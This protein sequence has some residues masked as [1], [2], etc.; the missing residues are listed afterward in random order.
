MNRPHPTRPAVVQRCV[1]VAL[2]LALAFGAAPPRPTRAQPLA[3]PDAN[4]WGFT[5][6][7]AEGQ[8]GFSDILNARVGDNGG[9][10]VY[11]TRHGAEG[12]YVISS[13]TVITVATVGTV[14]SGTLGTIAEFDPYNVEVDR[15]NRVVFTARVTGSSLP[16][17]AFSI[18]WPAFRW[19]NGVIT[20]LLPSASNVQHHL[21]TMT[22]QHQWLA[23][24]TTG[25]TANGSS[26][27][28][29]TDGVTVTPITTFTRTASGC[30]FVGYYSLLDLNASGTLL[31]APRHHTFPMLA[32]DA[33]DIS[34]F[35]RQWSLG[36]AGTASSTIAS[37]QLNFDF[38][39]GANGTQI[40]AAQIN[41]LGAVAY[42]KN[43]HT[44][45]FD[46]N[47]ITSQQLIRHEAG[48]ETVLLTT[49]PY[50][51]L[52]GFD[53]AGRVALARLDD[54]NSI[55]LYAGPNLT[56]DRVVGLGD[57][58]FGAELWGLSVL[59]V[60][61]PPATFGDQRVF[62]FHY[63]LESGVA[64]V[65]LASKGVT[66][67][68]NPAGGAWSTAANWLPDEVP[69]AAT[70]TL[71]D[72]E[73]AYD[74]NVGARTSGRSS[75]QNGSVGFRSAA[76]DL[77]GPLAVGADGAL[78][79]PEGNVTASD[80]I[81]GSLPP[82]NP[83]QPPVARL[84]LSNAG[85]VI[86]STGQTL[87]GQAGDGEVFI[88]GGRLASAEVRL[89]AGSPGTATVGLPTASWTM[90]DLAVGYSHTGTLN[91]ERGAFVHLSGEAVVG[92]GTTK[93][94]WLASVVADHAGT[95]LYGGLGDWFIGGGLTIG[96]GLLGRVLL[97]NGAVAASNEQVQLGL[98][99]HNLPQQYDG[100]L[101]ITGVGD[102]HQTVSALY[103]FADL[104]A[105]MA[106]GVRTNIRVANGGLVSVDNVSLAHEPG[107][108]AYLT[109][110]GVNAHG[111]RSTVTGGAT[112]ST[113]DCRIGRGGQALVQVRDGALFTCPAVLVG[114]ETGG[115]GHLFVAGTASGQAA[116]VQVA[117]AL[118]VGG[119]PVCASEANVRGRLTVQDGGRVESPALVVGVNGTVGGNGQIVVDQDLV[120]VHGTLD[121]GI[122]LVPALIPL[123]QQM[124]AGAA[125]DVAPPPVPGTLTLTG[126]LELAE[127][128]RL[129]ADVRGP[130]AGE[131][132]RLVV[133]GA[134][135]LNGVLELH[136]T[137]GFAPQQG[138]VFTFAQAGSLGGAF[139]QVVVTGL[140]PGFAYTVSTAGGALGLTAL[141]D[142]VATTTPVHQLFVP[143][144]RR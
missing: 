77:V 112:G 89:G 55:S 5:S 131:Y 91:I 110:T 134:A 24:T 2:V 62:A 56:N 67:W 96:N 90:V 137:N 138:D 66:R 95:T 47:E 115:S 58:L 43:T 51:Y 7:V 34:Q 70:E 107:S 6:V 52:L 139:D 92:Q 106:E 20:H 124:A 60:S 38:Q 102:D 114:Y 94:P 118:C 125:V 108:I 143:L 100:E 30:V 109:I 15:S 22:S 73:A 16:A 97:T 44:G 132:D 40:H 79:L 37:G 29:R 57:T 61:A 101:E 116:T 93:Q 13:G 27:M 49:A 78:T 14:L 122:E 136:F 75:V 59:D 23:E 9:V 76:L 126:A 41:D 82:V 39:A 1:T 111:Q 105:G 36:L 130:N 50:L 18:N 71:F 140:A 3:A 12:L 129:V 103:V 69:G 80:L 104:L 88:S 65:A 42:I 87:I 28:Q 19:H 98:Q 10:V 31:H 4:G 133:T 35:T 8:N 53:D 81:V 127:T 33:C 63:E 113:Y 32:P 86:T 84:N 17:P 119:T 11:G 85:T 64:G 68:I 135:T 123:E 121:P 117:H 120:I 25:T 74:V 99:A 54:T 45:T 141:N 26:L 144:V 21:T 142:G 48:S 72:L 128:G 83:A 46:E